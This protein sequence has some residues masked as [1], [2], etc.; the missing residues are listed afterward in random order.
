[1]GV[2]FLV[3]REVNMATVDQVLQEVHRRYEGSVDYPVSGDDD[4]DL[5]LALCGD[6]TEAWASEPYNWTALY[7][8]LADAGSGDTTTDGTAIID[9]PTNYLRPATMIKIGTKY[10]TFQRKDSTFNSLRTDSTTPFFT[11]TGDYGSMD[12]TVNPT[13]ETGLAVSY[14][15]IKAPTRPT[16]GTD[17]VIVPRHKFLVYY[18][19]AALYEQDF[20]NDMV[21]F[22]EGKQ[23]EEIARMTID[24]VRKPADHPLQMIDIGNRLHGSGFGV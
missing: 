1:M 11:V 21:T 6:G 13:P 8:D 19:L 23:S 16:A 10:Y 7:V 4:Y 22:Y 20:R 12:I 15:Y 14:G 17:T 2:A 3:P 9:C 5:R 24:H 18:I